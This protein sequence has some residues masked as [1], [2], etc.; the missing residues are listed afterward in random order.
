MLAHGKR[1]EG[2]TT[3]PM[4]SETQLRAVRAYLD[5]KYNEFF[6]IFAEAGSDEFEIL[7][8]DEDIISYMDGSDGWAFSEVWV[9][10]YTDIEVPE[11]MYLQARYPN[12]RDE[13]PIWSMD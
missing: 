3:F 5:V 11:Q 13:V 1:S 10:P 4:P 9:L 12:E 8:D 7:L 6:A 2:H